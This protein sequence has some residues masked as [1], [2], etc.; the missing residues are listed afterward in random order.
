MDLST[1][2]TN[3]DAAEALLKVLANRYRLMLLCEMHKGEKSVTALQ[4]VVGLSQSAVSQHLARLRDEGLVST[5]RDAQT[6]Y[7][8]LASE[9]AARI[10]ATLY[11]I[12]C[13]HD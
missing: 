13:K 1:L 6:I 5:R 11:D 2:N 4:Q 12:Y 8:A 3:A 7:Y 9:N 10:I